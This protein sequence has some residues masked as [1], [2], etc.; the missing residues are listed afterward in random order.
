MLDH[1]T[2]LLPHVVANPGAQH[3]TDLRR[4]VVGRRRRPL[5]EHLVIDDDSP[6]RP[7][8]RRQG[9][10]QRGT[11]RHESASRRVGSTRPHRTAGL[12]ARF[13]RRGDHIR[14]PRSPVG[15]SAHRRRAGMTQRF[16]GIAGR[17]I[18]QDS[19]PATSR[20][21]EHWRARQPPSWHLLWHGRGARFVSCRDGCKRPQVGGCPPWQFQKACCAGT[22]VGELPRPSVVPAFPAG[23]SQTCSA[24]RESRSHVRMD[25]IIL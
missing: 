6:R 15:S 2:L 22:F 17:V 24:W 23:Q 10:V 18:V 14:C 21:R 12:C 8:E 9:H 4:D 16:S 11:A 5:L 1:E 19:G 25:S 20:R 3:P 7:Q 13:G